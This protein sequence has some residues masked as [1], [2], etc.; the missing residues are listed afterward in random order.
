VG[1]VVG[2]TRGKKYLELLMEYR[3][4]NKVNPPFLDQLLQVEQLPQ[5][6]HR[7]LR[8]SHAVAHSARVLEDLVV[9]AALVRLVAKEVN[10]AVLD[11]SDLLLGLDVLQAVS[12]VPA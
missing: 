8:A 1:R 12:L 5:L 4:K 10:R 6:G 7:L 2:K 11:S 9:V 3:S